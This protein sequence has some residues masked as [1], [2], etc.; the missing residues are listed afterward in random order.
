MQPEKRGPGWAEFD[1][2]FLDAYTGGE[3]DLRDDVLRIFLEQSRLLLDRLEAAL[4]GN[5]AWS[6]AAH[7]LK[8]CARSVGANALADLA[9]RA[10]GEGRS[11]K[12]AREET[13]AALRAALEDTHAQ[14]E[15][16]MHKGP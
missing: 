12:D 3:R 9:R 13:L 8:G 4:N 2:A 5:K 6:E 16:L 7:S 10:E 15:A 1:A 14:V 11:A